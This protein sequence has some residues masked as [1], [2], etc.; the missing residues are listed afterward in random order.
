MN[1]SGSDLDFD[2]NFNKEPWNDCKYY[3]DEEFKEINMVGAFSVIHFNCRSHFPNFSVIVVSETW[4]DNEKGSYVEIEGYELFT[5]NR[6]KKKGGGVALYVDINLRCKSSDK[7]TIIIDGVME[8]ISVEIAIEGTKPII[9]SCLYRTPG[10]CLNTFNQ[11]VGSLF[12]NLNKVHIV[13]GDFNIDLLNPHDNLQ[14]SNFITTMYSNN[15]L[16]LILKPTRITTTTATLIDNV[17]TNEIS[18][19][20]TAGLLVNDISDHLPVFSVFHQIVHYAQNPETITQKLVRHGKPE[21]LAAHKADLSAQTWDEVFCTEDPNLAYDAFLSKVTKLYDKHCPLKPYITENKIKI[22]K[23]W[24]TYGIVKACKKKNHL[25]RIY[26]KQ[27]TK[28]AEERYK[29]YKNKLI[30]IIRM[31]KKITIINY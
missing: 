1:D 29:T 15:L 10:S 4:L 30:N 28:S 9:V 23:P 2:G 17:F 25:Y 26:L 5:L 20:I 22:K 8:C 11:E 16:P 6:N 31:N 27:R 19:Q 21:A 3:S 24:I 14:I 7:K 12:A 18:R 13:C